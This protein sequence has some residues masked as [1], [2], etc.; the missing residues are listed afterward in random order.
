M[1]LTESPV[2]VTDKADLYRPGPFPFTLRITMSPTTAADEFGVRFFTILT[3]PFGVTYEAFIVIRT[4][5]SPWEFYGFDSIGD[6]ESYELSGPVPA[7]NAEGYHVVDF[8]FSSF[9][10][11][12][13]MSGT[14]LINLESDALGAEITGWNNQANDLA[15]TFGPILDYLT[16]EVC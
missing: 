15:F 6:N 1:E 4:D 2:T 13:K 8:L 7:P 14:E 5:D 3:V 10:I 12:V 9:G 11:K 16:V